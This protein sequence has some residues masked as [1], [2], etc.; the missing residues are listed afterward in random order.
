MAR[1]QSQV[2]E[3][4]VAF[5]IPILFGAS[6]PRPPPPKHA[7]PFLSFLMKVCW[8]PQQARRRRGRQPP[9]C[10]Q[11]HPDFEFEVHSKRTITEGLWYQVATI[12]RVT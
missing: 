9:R 6:L 12:P 5:D 2:V 1:V 11:P 3:G 7:S 4:V 8:G 10:A